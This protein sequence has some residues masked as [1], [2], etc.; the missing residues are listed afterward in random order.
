MGKNKS[1][2]KAKNSLFSFL[3]NNLIVILVLALSIFFINI[4]FSKKFENRKLS[5]YLDDMYYLET[6][7]EKEKYFLLEIETNPLLT[8]DFESSNVSPA[9]LHFKDGNISNVLLDVDSNLFYIDESTNEILNDK[10]Y[11]FNKTLHQIKQD[12]KENRNDVVKLDLNK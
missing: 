8:F 3:K 5:N 9:I 11:K 7:E 10:V 12:E 2:N 4:A 6:V 1:A